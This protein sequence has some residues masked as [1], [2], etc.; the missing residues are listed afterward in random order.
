LPVTG[1]VDRFTPA[2]PAA[3]E[4]ARDWALLRSSASARLLTELAAQSGVAPRR[5]LRGT[6]I[7]RRTLDD[8]AGEVTTG[9]E[10][11]LTRNLVAELGGLPGL[12]LEAG[13]RYHLTTYGVWGFAMIA[14][15]T[16][17]DAVGLVRRSLELTFGLCR[18]VISQRAGEL[19]IELDDRALP[20][21]VRRFSVERE[22]AAIDLLGRELTGAQIP[23]RRL[24]F[25]FPR[26]SYAERDEE[27]FA[28]APA[29]L[30]PANLL[31]ID[32]AYLD[33]PL[34]QAF[35]PTAELCE[36]LS[37][38]LLARRRAHL[39]LV[40]EVRDELARRPAAMPDLAAVAGA[41][42]VSE[43]TLRRR[44][45]QQG[46]SFR[47]IVDDTR[48]ALAER[49]L[50]VTPTVHE[51]AV[52]LGYADASSFSHAFKRWTGMAPGAYARKRAG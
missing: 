45:E 13:S 25:R 40:G 20:P 21:A 8:P 34:P 39:G 4:G 5:I 23:L 35:A 7:D 10:L 44:L 18:T 48:R 14:S 11:A 28:I 32:G 52:R 49:L 42:N 2:T 24:T 3:A 27:V 29:F 17:G 16:L 30:Q 9:Q 33:M 38:E 50:E 31:A 26:P 43:R 22:A 1:T 15:P 51:V 36:R 47:A 46:I 6:G 12:G 37:L 19:V 41:L